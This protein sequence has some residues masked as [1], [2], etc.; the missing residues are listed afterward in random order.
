MRAPSE[1]FVRDVQAEFTS[2]D[3]IGQKLTS[4]IRPGDLLSDVDVAI[5]QIKA[6]SQTIQEAMRQRLM[7]GTVETIED[8]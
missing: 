4:L 1:V 6:A 3:P 2:R 5:H 8:K 7:D